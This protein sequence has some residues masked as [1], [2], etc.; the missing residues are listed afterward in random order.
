MLQYIAY[1]R[2]IN[3]AQ[4]HLKC[5][6]LCDFNPYPAKVENMVSS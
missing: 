4:L 5:S 3:M 2:Y 1:T 6:I